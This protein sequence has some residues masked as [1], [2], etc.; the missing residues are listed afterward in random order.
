MVVVDAFAGVDQ[1]GVE[2]VRL[3]VVHVVACLDTGASVGLVEPDGELVTD[4]T[5]CSHEGLEE[6]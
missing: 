3:G 6:E 4:Q 2:H 1:S 5:Q